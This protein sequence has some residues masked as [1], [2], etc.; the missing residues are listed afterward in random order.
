MLAFIIWAM[1][2][3]GFIGL[4]IYNILSKR[5]KPAGFWANAKTLPMEDVSGYNKAVGK[6]WC[7]FGG[8]LILLGLPLLDGQNSPWIMI[9][10]LGVMAE[11]IVAMAVY[12]TV[13]EK[14]YR[15]K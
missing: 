8:V 2:G 10:I 11:S 14:K 1:L 9:S 5:D 3:A 15:K 4:G 7:V 6:M 12:T 13:I